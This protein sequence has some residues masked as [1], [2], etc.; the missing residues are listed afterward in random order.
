MGER[1][2]VELVDSFRK[3][4]QIQHHHDVLVVRTILDQVD[5]LP[6]VLLTQQSAFRGRR[7]MAATSARMWGAGRLFAVPLRSAC[8]EESCSGSPDEAP[9]DGSTSTLLQRAQRRHHPPALFG[10]LHAERTAV[11]SVYLAPRAGPLAPLALIFANFERAAEY[12]IQEPCV[13]KRFSFF[14]YE[15]CPLL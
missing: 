3:Q 1:V 2:L 11:R 4:K 8:G 9:G 6:R 15:I 13:H 14:Q 10:V 12:M 7:P 5:Q